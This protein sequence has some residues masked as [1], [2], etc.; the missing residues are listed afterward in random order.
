MLYPLMSI[1]N[2]EKHWILSSLCVG[3]LHH[4]EYLMQ[5]LVEVRFLYIVVFCRQLVLIPGRQKP[6]ICHLPLASYPDAQGTLWCL[7]A[8]RKGLT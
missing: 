1:L 5:W 8:T 6:T 4:A 7:W 3:A 2:Y